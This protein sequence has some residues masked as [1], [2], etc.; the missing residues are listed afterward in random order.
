MWPSDLPL[1][2]LFEPFG[3]IF[4]VLLGANLAMFLGLIV[5]RENWV[6]Q[7]RH[8]ERI[9]VRLEP[10]VER[11][12]TSDDP[13]RAADEVTPII[14]KLGR[15]ARPVVA[16]L[17]LD[18]AA[19]ADAGTRARLREILDRSGAIELAERG[20]RRRIPWRR[21]LACE[22]L[23]AIGAERSIPVL[24]ARLEDRRAEVRVA[25]ARALGAI[26]SEKGAP[27]LVAAFLERRSVPTGVAHDA[28]RRLGPAGFDAFRQGLGSPD[29]TLRVTSCFGVAATAASAPEAAELL[30]ETLDRDDS[31]RVRAAATKA[32]ASLPL[33]ADGVPLG[34]LLRAARDTDTRVRREAVAALGRFDEPDSVELL[35]GLT[36]DGDRETALRSAESL[37]ALT[38]GS[39]AGEPARRALDSS[40][41]WATDHV[42][43][44][45]ELTA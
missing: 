13:Q 16:W 22:I 23:G 21:A 9:R 45:A 2:G 36:G 12:K 42:R 11:L 27:P 5:V 8:R 26:G 38:R 24:T 20:T 6:L 31:A 39:R 41:G 7:R 43:T 30:A 4:L 25:A 10:V 37:F 28:L 17:V 35:A 18:L 32:L 33:S 3:W 40:T 29:A 14:R 15:Q 19:E 44:V 1:D 34:T